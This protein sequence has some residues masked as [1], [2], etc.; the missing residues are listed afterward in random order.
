MCATHSHQ[1]HAVLAHPTVAAMA[2]EGYHA[3]SIARPTY[4]AASSP[5]AVPWPGSK[6]SHA[7][8]HPPTHQKPLLVVEFKEYSPEFSFSFFRDA[9]IQVCMFLDVW[10]ERNGFV[11]LGKHAPAGAVLLWPHMRFSRVFKETYDT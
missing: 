7:S 8:L 6:R 10:D 11:S 2:A 1:A 3:S 9:F 4:Y 5:R